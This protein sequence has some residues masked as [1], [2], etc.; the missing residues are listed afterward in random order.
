IVSTQQQECRT[1]RQNKRMSFVRR[2]IAKDLEYIDE[3]YYSGSNLITPT[4]T[5][6]TEM[7][8]D[9]INENWAKMTVGEAT[10][11]IIEGNGFTSFGTKTSFMLDLA[12][13][14]LVKLSAGI[15]YLGN[16]TKLNLSNNQLSSLPT[17]I[18]YLQ[19]LSVFNASNNKIDSIP[20][21]IIYLTKLKAINI[22]H[23]KI[24]QLPNMPLGLVIIIANNNRIRQIPKEL[25][26]LQQLVTLNISHNPIR[27]LPAQ[28]VTI[29][30]LRKLET[31]G[32]D[33]CTEF[34]TDLPHNP[35]SLFEQC[36]RTIVRRQLDVG[37][38][39]DPIRAY[40]STH[41]S[42]SY[43]HG[44]YFESFVTRGRFIRRDQQSIAL[45]Y[46]LCCA[47]WRDEQDR[48]LHLFSTR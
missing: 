15:G 27:H 41:Q 33:F 21:T 24:T 31:D 25:A 36:A 9:L 38:L 29:N 10:L 45:E 37:S 17:S 48:L 22:S 40:L 8:D 46:T 1:C 30:S 3:T 12:D 13:R 39:S 43:C 23:N 16:L 32:C 11:Q 18:G 7:D 34:I 14:S 35:P 44:P 19:N 2:H 5:T 47:H 28:L 42:C 20:D 6:T 4:A 26:K